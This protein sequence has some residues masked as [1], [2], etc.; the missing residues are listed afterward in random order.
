MPNVESATI[1][2]NKFEKYLFGGDNER[3]LNKGRLIE[4]RLGYNMDNHNKFEEEILSRARDYPA[5]FKGENQHGRKYE[6]QIIFYNKNN[7]PVNV[8]VAW[9]ENNGKTHMTTA[10]ITEVR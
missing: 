9:L 10:Y 5:T 7:E 3:G 4:K 2:K 1:D 8:I 6:Q